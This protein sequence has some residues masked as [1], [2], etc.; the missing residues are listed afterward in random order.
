MEEKKINVRERTCYIRHTLF[1]GKKTYL[2]RHNIWY[3]KKEFETEIGAAAI[4]MRIP[5]NVLHRGNLVNCQISFTD[6]FNGL[7]WNY[8]SF[9][10]NNLSLYILVI[11]CTSFIRQVSVHFIPVLSLS[12]IISVRFLAAHWLSALCTGMPYFSDFSLLKVQYY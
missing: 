10:F 5:N 1:G 6:V 7:T 12:L 11:N 8:L 4:L 9:N 3:F 2:S